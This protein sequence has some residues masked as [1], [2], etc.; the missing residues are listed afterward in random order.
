MPQSPYTI[1][2]I[3][4]SSSVRNVSGWRS[5]FGHNSE[6]KIA[7][8]SAI[9]VANARARTEEYSVPQM[10][11]RAPNSPDTGSQTSLIQNDSL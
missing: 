2:G 10:N 6:R 5:A 1:D 4:A 9:G 7:M 8:P 3:A 11:G